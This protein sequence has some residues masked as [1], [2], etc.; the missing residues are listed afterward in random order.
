MYTRKNSRNLTGEE[1][2]RFVGA[3]LELKRRGE[4]D[5]FVRMHI[6]FYVTDGQDGLRA[7]HMT[8]SF[9]PWHRRYLLEF[10]RALQRVDP[11]VTVPYW[12]WTADDSPA[13]ALWSDDFLGGN[14]QGPDQRV[15][16]GPFAYESGHWKINSGVTDREYL[17]RN[18]GRP[19]APIA[20]PTR[21]ELAWA[22]DEPVYDTAPWNS[23]VTSG[24]RNRLEGWLSEGAERWRNHNRVHRWV[25]GHMLGASSPNDP[26]FWL[27]HSFIDL[28]WDRWRRRH[29]KAVYQPSN[30]LHPDD[31]QHGRVISLD[32]P[33]PP[34]DVRPSE[35][36]DHSRLYRYAP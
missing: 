29:P 4:Y 22:M 35:L 12:D 25:G 10:E 7:A 26:V 18:F 6:E 9:F 27:H 11:A 3:V 23:T 30:R 24:F 15:M 1:R 21:D 16:T 36:L 32:E 8:P 19:S 14:G 17:T 2:Q 28:L 5:D 20:L 34:W 31:P 13:A 33:M